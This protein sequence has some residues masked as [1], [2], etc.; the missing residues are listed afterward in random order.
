MKLDDARRGG[1]NEAP[2]TEGLGVQLEGGVVSLGASDRAVADGARVALTT[3]LRE[4]ARLW[5]AVDHLALR[6]PLA[7]LHGHR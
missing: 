4:P 7:T 6:D 5:A 1:A 2:S 3:I